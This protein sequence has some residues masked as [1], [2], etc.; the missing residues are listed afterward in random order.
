MPAFRAWRAVP[1]GAA[2]GVAVMLAASTRA[3]DDPALVARGQVFFRSEGCYGCHMVGKFGTAIGPNLS[4]IG[5]KYS[6]E[7]LE[8]WVRDP[9]SQRPSAHMPKLELSTEHVEA[10]AAYLSTLR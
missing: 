4:Y 7:Y 10:L 1:I 9:A 6:R 2:V 3:E 5:A 8:R